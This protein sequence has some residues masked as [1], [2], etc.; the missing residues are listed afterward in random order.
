M[1]SA[2]LI[3]PPPTDLAAAAGSLDAELSRL[4]ALGE[5][6]PLA[7]ATACK[8]ALRTWPR[9]A[10]LWSLRGLLFVQAG[11][12]AKA[13]VTLAVALELAPGDVA[14][15]LALARLWLER[16]RPAA[17]LELIE[18]APPRPKTQRKLLYRAARLAIEIGDFHAAIGR[19]EPALGGARE[20]TLRALLDQAQRLRAADTAAGLRAQDKRVYLTGVE[21]LVMGEPAAAEALFGAVVASSPNYAP[22]WA[23]LKGAR[24]AQDQAAEIDGAPGPIRPFLERRFSARG[25]IFDPREVVPE[26]PRAEALT[27]V[28]A[29]DALSHT[30]DSWLRLDPVGEPMTLGPTITLGGPG[31][32]MRLPFAAS[33]TFVAGLDQPALLGRGIAIDRTGA[34]I[35]ELAGHHGPDKSSAFQV[36]RAIGFDRAVFRDGAAPVRFV[37]E[38]AFLMAGPSDGAFGDWMTNFLPRLSLARRAGVDA[39]LVIRSASQPFVRQTLAFLGVGPD[40]ILEHDPAGVTLFRRLYVPSWPMPNRRRAMAGL[41]AALDVAASEAKGPSRLYLSREHMVPRPLINEAEV[42]A[43]FEAHGFHTIHPERLS[44][45][46]LHALLSG[47]DHVAGPYGSAFL[48]LAF[49][50]R[51]P[52]CLVCAP[53]YYLGFQREVTLWLGAMGAPFGLFLG[54]NDGQPPR[55]DGPWSVDLVRLEAAISRFLQS[56]P[57]APR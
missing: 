25:L 2:S 20:P 54:E 35:A 23:G 51:K 38:P 43:R 1:P 55:R 19:L 24:L 49:C 41:M 57:A 27:E 36:G 50:A 10:E 48:N 18:A 15:R 40:R 12:R 3:E 53:A 28:F 6:D 44:L 47:A 17:A 16:G 34:R 39:R 5:N 8:A 30:P 33:E 42:R 52:A 7:G 45:A 56:P 32:E 21:K 26:R 11:L 4:K 31:D 46:A 37:D 13:E 29:P 9:S 14:A 22:A